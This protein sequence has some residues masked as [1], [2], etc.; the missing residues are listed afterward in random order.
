[1]D[2][3]NWPIDKPVRYARNARKLTAQA[4]DKVAASIQEYGFRQAIVVDKAG[5]I[6]CGHTRLLAA[7]PDCRR[8]D[9][10]DHHCRPG[11]HHDSL[12]SRSHRVTG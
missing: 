7:Q 5:V 4:V 3:E 10:P 8:K 1:M 11:L 12:Q 6:I 9:N 2:I